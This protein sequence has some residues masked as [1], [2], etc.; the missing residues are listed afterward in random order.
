MRK[1]AGPSFSV[2]EVQ[3]LRGFNPW[4]Q[5]RMPGLPQFRRT[6][7][8]VALRHLDDPSVR[9]AVLLS[10]PRR[11]GKTTL[12]QQIAASLV[13]DG[14][15]PASV[16]YCSLDHPVLKPLPLHRILALY[17]ETA[18]PEGKPAT[19]LLDEVQY[20][21]DWETEIKLLV[22]HHPNY[23]ILATGSA[24]ALHHGRLAESG[25]G[26]W[27][28]VPMPTLSFYEFAH[29]QEDVSPPEI[30]RCDLPGL[31][32]MT[33]AQLQGLAA[34]MRPLRSIFERYLVRGGFPESSGKMD[35][36][37]NQ[38]LLREDVI[39]KVL[40]HDLA[41]LLKARNLQDLEN[42]FLYIC[43]HSGS[44]VNTATCAKELGTTRYIVDHY[45]LALEQANLVYRL[46]PAAL[47]GKKVLKPRRK[48]YVVDAALRNAL[49]LR[50]DEVVR[51]VEEI[52][53]IVETAVLRHLYAFYY[54]DSPEIVYWR[55][56]KIRREVDM[57]VR[58]PRYCLPFEV[59]YRKQPAL[60]QDSGLKD[61][62]RLEKLDFAYLVVKRDQDF[63]QAELGES[64]R[65]L[66]IP[67]HTLCYIL[68]RAERDL[69]QPPA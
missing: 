25:A 55:E 10:G 39:G 32:G 64:T 44:I 45:L 56:P 41:E 13:E 60:K 1:E 69:W 63:K 11:V 42:L 20:S 24:S 16:F 37:L 30:E 29:L 23:R 36:D 49:F 5:Q 7:F 2:E 67:A 26:R 65:L 21:K 31:Q 12:F 27:I 51:N 15:D 14:A 19:L 17:H 50:G 59:K 3:V 47:G 28:P 35:L 43:L 9:R 46:P 52:G 58:T 66:Q 54:R 4:W 68:G 57:I 8:S 33:N 53:L 40:K 22:D 48:Y 38:R 34:Q 18:W 62:C 6:A 61:F